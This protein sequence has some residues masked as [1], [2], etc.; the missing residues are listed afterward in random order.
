[1]AVWN[2]RANEIFATALEMLPPQR[3]AYLEQVC[4]GDVELLQQVEGLLATHFQAGDFLDRPV[5]P[6]DTQSPST[7][8]PASGQP[9]PPDAGVVRA[10]AGDPQASPA[11]EG[12]QLP[13][14]YRMEGEIARGGMGCV[15]RGRD[16]ELG[17]EIAVKVL[18]QT[19]EG[20]TELVQRF[21]EEAQ[22][23]G[24]L[25]HPGIAPIY[26]MAVRAG[27]LPFFTMKLVKGETLARLLHERQEP[28]QDRPRFVKVF[29]AVCQTLAYA[30]ARDVIH[31]DLKPANI[32]V[33]LRRGPGHGLGPCQGPRAR[34]E[35]GGESD[36]H[37]R[38]LPQ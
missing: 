17:R 18:L 37:H 7:E 25:Q 21:V 11:A 13:P 3:Q 32:M 12:W 24:Q 34:R 30:H 9:V 31:R 19:H 1:M 22:I 14:R 38:H 8:A 35:G 27:N 28:G 2:P 15:L 23:A 10:L 36:Q 6:S 29:E 5:L 26:D 33:G 4:D 20:R 16:T